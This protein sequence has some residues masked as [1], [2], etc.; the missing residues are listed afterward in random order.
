MMIQF[1]ILYDKIL[2]QT[3]NFSFRKEMDAKQFLYF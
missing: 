3:M 1:D 2:Y